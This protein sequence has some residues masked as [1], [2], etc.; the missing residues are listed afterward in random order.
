[1]KLHYFPYQL[2]FKHPFSTSHGT[3]AFTDVIFVEL[4]H[5]GITGYGEAALP[6]YL[7]ETPESVT[8]LLKKIDFSQFENPLETDKILDEVD[9]IEKRNPAAKA[10]VDIA[11][12]DLAGKISSNS[13]AEIY[14]IEDS[15]MPDCTFTIGIGDAQSIK[16]KIKEAEP[17]NILKVKLGSEN[18]KKA[19][20]IITSETDKPFCVDVNQGWKDWRFAID[21]VHWLAEKG[22]F[23]VEQP[24][25][26]EMLNESAR[27]MEESPI[28][29]IADESCQRL[30]D[31]ERIKGAFSGIN[32][33]LMKSTG[34]S[35]AHKMI[36]LAKELEMKVLI[37]CMSESSCGVTAAAHLAPLCD[38]ADL[39]GPYLIKNDPFDGMKIA[40]GKVHVSNG[41][42]ICANSN[43]LYP[44][45]SQKP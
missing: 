22:A 32:V 16:E 36:K 10:A 30:Q 31:I 38:W 2:Q 28:P 41:T 20:E 26:K 21:T 39:D 33:K 34:I 9:A 42:G 18:D 23:L 19:I 7:E 14:G 11:L 12:H 4:E 25:P 43:N 1:M 15:E 27:I 44:S 35:E 29:I 3:R 45:K 17:F 40:N 13:V 8:T 24:L 37:G 5:N 6:P